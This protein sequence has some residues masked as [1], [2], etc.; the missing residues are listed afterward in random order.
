MKGGCLMT[1]DEWFVKYFVTQQNTNAICLICQNKIACLKEFNIRRHYNSLH[2]KQYDR[3]LGQLRVDKANKLK[4]LLQG[5]QKMISVYKDNSQITTELSYKISEAIA[6]KGKAFSDG[7]FVKH[8]LM[9]FAERACPE[10]KYLIEQTSLSRFTVGLRTDTLSSY[11]EDILA[12]NASKFSYYSLAVDESTD[13]AQLVVFIRGVNDEFQIKEFLDLASMKS[14]TTG[15][16]LTQEVLKMTKKYQLDPKKLLG[17]TTDGAPAMV[18]KHKG[19]CKTFLEAF[20]AQKVV[21]NHCIIHQEN[22]C[23]KVLDGIVIMKEVVY[24]VNYIRSRGLNH[25]QFKVFLKELDCDYPDITYFSSV[26]W[27]SR[28]DTSKKNFG[29]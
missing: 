14:T 6:E 23:N 16:D 8:C 28:A 3:I 17:L 7:E 9:I 5:Q 27:F 20:G 1:I 15:E 10:K 11:L 2:S 21:L 4:R 22:L 19:F 25:R 24:C 26:R 12:E 29:I 18:G 13:T